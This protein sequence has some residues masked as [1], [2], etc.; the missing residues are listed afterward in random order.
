MRWGHWGGRGTPEVKVD[1]WGWAGGWVGRGQGSGRS[2]G[3][4]GGQGSGQWRQWAGPRCRATGSVGHGRRAVGGGGGTGRTV[5]SVGAARAAWFRCSDS[6]VG[7]SRGWC[8]GRGGGSL[9]GV[10]WDGW[11]RLGSWWGGWAVGGAA[12]LQSGGHCGAPGGGGRAGA[13]CQIPSPFARAMNSQRCT[14][15]QTPRARARLQPAR[16]R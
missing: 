15:C 8:T 2:P 1:E 14:H 10:G 7:G 11:L 3:Q 4:V 5:G 9:T 13:V 6:E 12:A 16:A